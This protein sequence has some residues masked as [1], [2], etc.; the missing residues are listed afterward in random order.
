M[1]TQGNSPLELAQEGKKAS[2]GQWPALSERVGEGSIDRQG[3]ALIHQ[4]KG[5]QKAWTNRETRCPG[6]GSRNGMVIM[7]QNSPNTI[8]ADNEAATKLGND[9][10]ILISIP[11]RAFSHFHKCPFSSL[12]SRGG[13]RPLYL[14][15]SKL[16]LCSIPDRPQKQSHCNIPSCLEENFNV[17]PANINRTL[18]AESQRCHIWDVIQAP[19][20]IAL[21][22]FAK[23]SSTH[24]T[25]SS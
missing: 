24:F 23:T 21:L 2:A 25:C 20:P 19:V 8:T 13:G 17:L 15:V 11:Q 1:Q 3:E 4:D 22:A 10:R 14:A 9:V 7:K 12:N 16:I 5:D 6:R 18:L